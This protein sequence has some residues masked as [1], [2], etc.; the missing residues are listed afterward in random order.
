MIWFVKKLLI[1]YSSSVNTFTDVN[2]EF[3]EKLRKRLD[4]I[5]GHGWMYNFIFI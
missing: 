4:H 1:S 3:D 5:V 2:E